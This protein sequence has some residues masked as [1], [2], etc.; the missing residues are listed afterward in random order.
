M[1]TK[2]FNNKNNTPQKHQRKVR[3]CFITVTLWKAVYISDPSAPSPQFSL[4][5]GV[6]SALDAAHA[7]LYIK[8]LLPL[9]FSE[10]A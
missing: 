7:F 10:L 8:R 5:A 4:N 1:R 6:A 9:H 3:F 2:T